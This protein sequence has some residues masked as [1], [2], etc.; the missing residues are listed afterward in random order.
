[1]SQFEE[2]WDSEDISVEQLSQSQFS[3]QSS[4]VP[5]EESEPNNSQQVT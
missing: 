3:S 5:S 2:I 1:M 4:Y